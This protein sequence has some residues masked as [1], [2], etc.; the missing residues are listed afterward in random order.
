MQ[1]NKSK[2]TQIFIST[3]YINIISK[4][5]KFSRI[6]INLGKLLEVQAEKIQPRRGEAC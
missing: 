3:Y 1:I 2:H 5:M 6:K 4:Y